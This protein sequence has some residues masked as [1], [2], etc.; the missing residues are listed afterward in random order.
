MKILHLT[1]KYPDALG[2]DAVVVS[3]L[4]KEQT[5]IGHEV[6]ILTS[7]C[8]EIKEKENVFKFGLKDI[9][10]NLDRITIRRV[11]SLIILLFLGFKYLRRLK[12]DVIHAHSADLDLPFL[13]PPDCL[14]FL[15]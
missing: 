13:Y 11:I 2:G 5:K 3:N 12:P 14:A 7:N 8:P 4:E 6:F 15:L 9:S 10:L 1:K